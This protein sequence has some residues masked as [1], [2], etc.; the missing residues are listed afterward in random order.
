MNRHLTAIPVLLILGACVDDKSSS[1][2]QEVV[3]P[4]YSDQDGDYILDLHEGFIDPASEDTASSGSVSRD[5]DGDGTPDY[6]DTDSD[7]DGILDAVE[8]GDADVWTL[9]WDS[10]TDMIP[11]YLDLDSDGNCIPDSEDGEGEM[12]ADGIRDYADLDDDGD[13]IKD[14]YEIGSDCEIVDSDGDGTPDYRD[15]S[16]IH[17]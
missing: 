10:D 1:P 9:P 17:I 2:D 4:T 12:D 16:L 6:L 13:T 15:L 3:E 14:V 7:G 8:G 5:T 11:D